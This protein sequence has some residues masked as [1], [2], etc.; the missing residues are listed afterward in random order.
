MRGKT[1]SDGDDYS[2]LVESEPLAAYICGRDGRVL[3][4]NSLVRHLWKRDFDPDD[5]RQAFTGPCHIL[6]RDLTEV[7]A[8]TL[9]AAKVLQSQEPEPLGDYVLETMGGDRCRIKAGAK[10]VRDGDLALCYV[11]P[12]GPV[13]TAD[14]GRRYEAIVEATPESVEVVS[15][16]GILQSV[17]EAG[18]RIMEAGDRSDIVGKCVFDYIVPEYRDA[19]RA[20]HDQV[21][22]GRPATLE[23]ELEGLKGRRRFVD[24]HAVPLEGEGRAPQR[25]TV[26]RDITERK[27]TENLLE[28]ERATLETLNNLSRAL[29]S[30]L[31]LQALVQLATDKVTRV[32]GAEFGAFFYNIIS[33]DGEALQLYTLSGA[34]K[35]IFASFPHPRTTP[36]LAP[37]FHGEGTIVSH[38]ITRDERYGRAGRHSG[39]PGGHLPVRSYLAVPVVSRGGEVLGSMLLGHSR[40]GMFDARA[41]RLAEGIAAFAA[42]GIDNSRLYAAV[43]SS[44]ARLRLLTDAM[45]QLVWS[46]RGDS[47]LCQYLSSQWHDYTGVPV[48]RLLGRGWMDVIHPDDRDRA[49]AAWDDARRRGGSYGVEY[50]ILGADGAYRWFKAR[51]EPVGG[52]PDGVPIWYGTCTDIQELMDA[53]RRAE[54][55]N[56]AKSEFLANMSHEIRTPMNAII[57]LSHILAMSQPLTPRQ[58]EFIATLRVSADALMTLINDLL[59]IEKIESGNVE[60]ER[61]TV[62]LARL[63]D[64]VATIMVFRAREKGLTLSHDSEAVRGRLFIGDPARLRQILLNLVGN[65]I[66]F[67]DKG[68]VRVRAVCEGGSVT[69]TVSDSGIG[70][71][72]DKADAIFEKFVQADS[73]ISRK[74]GGTGLGLAITRT[75]VHLMGGRLSVDSEVGRG[76]VFTVH[77]DL[78]P[79]FAPSDGPPAAEAVSASPPA[80]SGIVLLVED[81]EAN[82][83]VATT[84]LKEFGYQI[85][86]AGNGLEALE[87]ARTE[88]FAAVLMDIQMPGMDGLEATRLIREHERAAHRAPVPIIGMTAHARGSDRE[89][90]RDAGMNAYLP[91]PFKPEDL[92]RVLEETLQVTGESD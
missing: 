36:L 63:V 47:G 70:I 18:L 76:S 75:L 1:A 55:A 68:G 59:D 21:I 31:D 2:A 81:H 56:T 12:V 14:S 42:V 33:E 19:F 91:K 80:G 72:P 74:Y 90:C 29:T 30:T 78:E 88:S 69:L 9:W 49:A 28:D 73:S 85:A 38:D 32:T 25:L 11:C 37:T 65:A 8:G 83:L 15:A 79:A 23:Y 43:Q 24:S 64:E 87:R 20:F 27:R 51:A 60:L 62:D 40:P 39:M 52:E 35:E 92:R 77:L 50:R 4:A 82:V 53:R 66:K 16:D 10:P 5:E 61:T 46:A 54:A 71:A 45:P 41:V 26:T 67:T 44:E 22:A 3:A 84:L 57:G 89:Q 6:S 17:N 48:T 34:K 7:D 86:V 58:Q 13:D